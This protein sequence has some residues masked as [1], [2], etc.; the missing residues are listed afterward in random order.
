[1]TGGGA[2]AQKDKVL[3]GK[4]PEM[5]SEFGERIS[6]DPEMLRFGLNWNHCFP[7]QG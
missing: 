7:D 5:D 3:W 6:V 2:M 1:M 4:G